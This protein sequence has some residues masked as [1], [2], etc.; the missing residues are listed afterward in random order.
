MLI[1]GAGGHA[2]EILGTFAENNQDENIFF[3][4]DYEANTDT[5]VFNKFKIL[6]TAQQIKEL[7]A[8]ENKFVIGIGN[9]FQR[10]NFVNKL[11]S[12][13][14]KLQSIISCKASIGKYN[15]LLGNGLNILTGAVITQNVTIGIGTL[16][17]INTTIHH[18]C[19]IG[20]YCEISP[21][22]NILGKVQIGNYC[23]IGAGAVVLP[24]IKIG[25]NVVIGAGA[26][27]TKNLPDNA[28][29]KGI[30]AK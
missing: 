30:P 16:I 28:M 12:L 8:I 2:K 11:V 6:K 25:D 23:S 14:G 20:N 4:D 24:K 27:V 13:G 3:F 1:A 29:V 9:P 26:V 19:I 17:H 21:N 7:F 22:C 15:V 5:L 10:E 18:D